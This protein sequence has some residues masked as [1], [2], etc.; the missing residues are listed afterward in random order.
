MQRWPAAE[1]PA[2][3]NVPRRRL[4]AG[5]LR[6]RRAWLEANSNAADKAPDTEPATSGDLFR[7]SL[8][9]C[10]RIRKLTTTP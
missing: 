6:G 2:G 7:F 9:D 4:I 3:N 8:S 5:S 1:V 10:G